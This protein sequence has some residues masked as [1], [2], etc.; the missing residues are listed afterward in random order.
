MNALLLLLTTGLALMLLVMQSGSDAMLQS[1]KHK[2]E[3]GMRLGKETKTQMQ[4]LQDAQALY[5]KTY[6]QYPLGGI[7]E[8][9]A[10]GFLRSNYKT[11][12]LSKNITIDANNTIK[13]NSTN[14]N[15]NGIAN[16]YINAH[17][18]SLNAK[19][20]KQKSEQSVN[21]SVENFVNNL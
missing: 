17:T 15:T 3:V 19:Q 7:D 9:I 18:N 2:K 6:K 21:E 13:V 5:F 4:E 16:S 11:T 8:L 1:M 12:Q 10:K 14:A 20:A